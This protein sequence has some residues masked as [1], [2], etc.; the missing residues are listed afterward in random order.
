[1]APDNLDTAQ[2]VDVSVAAELYR[3]SQSTIRSWRRRS[4]EWLPDPVA[5]LN[6]GS[7][8]R[9]SE[10]E[11]KA[12]QYHLE[13]DLHR[14]AAGN[15]RRRAQGS[16]YTS[17]DTAHFLADWLL[18]NEAKKIL[19]PSFGDGIFIAA[20]REQ[21]RRRGLERP[22]W[23]AVELDEDAIRAAASNVDL[24]PHEVR[25]ADFLSLKPQLVDAVIAN[26]PYVR[27]RHL[28]SRS[29]EVAQQA[30]RSAV[31]ASL[32]PAASVWLPFLIHA[33]QFLR[34]DGV[35]AMV[36]PSDFTYVAYARKYWKWLG[37]T[38]S[39]VS[40]LRVRERLFP[41][42]NQ[43]VVL[44]L[45]TGKGGRSEQV[46][47]KAFDTIADLL[48]EQ[49]SVDADISVKEILGGD[50]VFQRALAGSDAWAMLEQEFPHLLV[51]ADQLMQFRIGYV[52]GD[53]RY[54]HPDAEAIKKFRLPP[55][56]LVPTLTNARRLRGAGLKTASLPEGA[57]DSLWW[58]SNDELSPGEHAYINYGVE[59]GVS[60]GY[61]AS[62]RVPWYRVPTVKVPDV[63]LTVFSENPLLLIN[64]GHLQAS[65]S[66]LCGYSQGVDAEQF[67]LD[68]YSPITELSVATEVHAL[69]GGVMILVPNEANAVHLARLGRSAE[70][71]GRIERALE[72]GDVRAAYETGGEALRL[73]IGEDNS[74]LVETS[75]DRLRRWRQR[76]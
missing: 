25:Q 57:V 70:D 14:T 27:L 63:V 36:L 72:A 47:F 37:D 48:A 6:G 38:F 9:R 33:V 76:A 34:R 46:A 26:P 69:G 7:V 2:L 30:V 32:S 19:E 1:M 67:A 28:D 60:S 56:S 3:V 35:L 18:A 68:W 52:A 17:A 64:D 41:D 73:A 11:S 53:K 13:T 43:D 29:A 49:P 31:G 4:A 8:W 12:A 51:R 10:V 39:T 40:V 61:K 45:C 44:L 23:L 66:L 20:I 58:P 65:N 59:F 62:R 50:R 74:R 5:T 24:M 54:F 42:I 21:A 55:T 71:L 16:Y 15:A 22:D 75:I